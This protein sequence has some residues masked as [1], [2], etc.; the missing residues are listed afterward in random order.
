MCSCRWAVAHGGALGAVLPCLA[1]PLLLPGEF[2]YSTGF[3]WE[4][5]LAT[6]D[7]GMN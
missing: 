6:R 4:S 7:F 5:G 3:N 1:P 2:M